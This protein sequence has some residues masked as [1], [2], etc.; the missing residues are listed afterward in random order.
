M[1]GGLFF[2]R[3]G[4]NVFFSIVKRGKTDDFTGNLDNRFPLKSHMGT[5]AI[6]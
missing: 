6:V 2:R 4:F 3:Y 5:K 1:K